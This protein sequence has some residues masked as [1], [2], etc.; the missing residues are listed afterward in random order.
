MDVLTR[1]EV[2]AVQ[3][4]TQPYQRPMMM[5]AWIMRICVA[6]LDHNKSPAPIAAQ[7]I[8]HCLKAREGMAT[9][10]HYLDTQL[11]FAYVHLITF[12]VNVQN[13][14][15]AILSGVTVA[16]NFAAQN[17][18]GIIQQII[19]C[20]LVVLIYQSLLQITALIEDPFGDDVLDFPVKHYTTYIATMIDAF[21][22]AQ[23]PCPVVGEDGTLKRPREKKKKKQDPGMDCRMSPLVSPK[24]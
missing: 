18:T 7:I 2:E 16:V 3:K 10:N 22:E 21:Y 11:P 12:L 6:S 17:A 13:F 4:K 19:A 15:F 24:S 9:M 8:G 1:A 23:A 14:V 20:F 5:W